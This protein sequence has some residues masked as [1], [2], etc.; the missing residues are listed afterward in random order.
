MVTA[1]FGVLAVMHTAV[2]SRRVEI[3]MPKAIGS[4]ART[5][6]GAFI[7]EAIITLSAALAG[8]VAGVG[9]GLRVRVEPALRAGTDFVAGA[10]DFTTAGVILLMVCLAAVFS[11]GLATQP[12]IRQKA[13][14]ILREKKMSTFEWL[15]VRVLR[16]WLDGKTQIARQV[17]QAVRCSF[18]RPPSPVAP[19]TPKSRCVHIGIGRPLK[20]PR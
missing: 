16:W 20:L 3:G 15:R 19:I 1:V 6:R 18:G 17:N 2:T 9:I 8:I 5:L 10:F 14:R 7:G 11:A 13:I 12:V 4:P